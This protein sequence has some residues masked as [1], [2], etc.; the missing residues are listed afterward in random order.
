MKTLSG[1]NLA[2]GLV[3]FELGN[4]GTGTIPRVIGTGDFPAL[5]YPVY[6]DALGAF[7]TNLW[8]NDSIDPANTIYNVTFRDFMGNEVGPVMFSITGATFNLDTAAATNTVLP[9]ILVTTVIGKRLVPVGAAAYAG[10][11]AAI[12]L[13]AGWGSTAAVSGAIGTDGA[14][15]FTVTSNGTG[16][17][18]NATIA[19]T[20]KDGA[21]GLSPLF[22][23]MITGG[24]GP[25]APITYSTTT[26]VLTLT[27]N[28]TPIAG[29]TYVFTDI[30]IG[31]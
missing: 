18:A 13:G 3:I 20:Y 30:G 10:A 11:D 4:I 6:T 17:A 31:R 16:I 23:S 24:T 26:T 7:T 9:P 19:I 21:W 8:G 29:Q 5:K 2:Q 1:G 28:G 22:L 27:Y 14:H 12:V 15:S 25:I